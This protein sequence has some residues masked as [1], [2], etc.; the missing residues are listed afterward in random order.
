MSENPLPGTLPTNFTEE[1][2]AR[3][4][5]AWLV[6]QNG[7]PPP[8]WQDYLPAAEATCSA[9][10]ILMHLK[11]DIE[12]RIK[13]GLPAL[14]SERYFEHPRLQQEDARL[15]AEQQVELITWEYLQ[16][17]NQGVHPRRAEYEAAF[18][19]HADALRE[20]KPRSRCPR[21]DKLIVLEE[22]FQ[23]LLCPDCGCETSLSSAA[24]ALVASTSAPASA[25]PKLDL[26]DYELI[27][28]LG[29]GGMGEVY[30]CPDPALGRDLAIKVM[31]TEYQNHPAIEHRFLREARITGSLQH[32]N[33]VAVYNLG[34]LPDG[35][36][37]YTMRLV[38]GRTFAEILKEEGGRPER[39]PSLLAI[40]QKACEA[41]AYAHSKRVIHRDLKPVNIMVGKFG[42]VQVMAWGLSK[43]LSAEGKAADKE[44]LPEE[45]TLIHTESPDTP[46]DLT[47]AGSAI[48][49]PKYMPPEQ[50]QGDWESVDE[51]ADVFTLGAI[52]C[53]MLTGRPP[54]SGENSNEVLRRAKRGDLAEAFARLEQC[55]A[56]T[57]LM[58][59][60]RDCLLV[61]SQQRPRNAGIVA[62]RVTEHL[63]AVEQRLRQAELER[64]E[65]D[66]KSREERKRR[67][68]A[69]RLSAAVLL[70]LVAGTLISLLFAFDAGRQ[71]TAARNHAEN[72]ENEKL[73]ADKN[74]RD[75]EEEK[76]IATKARDQAE[77]AL[78]SGLLRPIG[79]GSFYERIQYPK[80]LLTSAEVDVLTNL[81]NLSADNL[82][83]RFFEE[84][85]RTAETAKRL[86]RRA[87][88]VIQASV[89]LDSVRR[90]KV[91]EMLMLRLRDRSAPLEV[92]EAC[93]MLG[94]LLNVKDPSFDKRVGEIT[95]EATSNFLQRNTYI[96]SDF[97]E[98]L[99][100]VS[101]RL[102]AAS[103][104]KITDL[105]LSAMKKN[106]GPSI[107]YQLSRSW[108]LLSGRLDK[109]STAAHATK[110]ADGLVLGIGQSYSPLHTG[111]LAQTLQAVC[112]H[113]DRPTAAAYADKAADLLVMHM[114]GQNISGL[115][116]LAQ[117]LQAVSDSLNASKAAAHA[118]KT[119]DLLSARICK[120]SEPPPVV[121]EKL[122]DKPP[123]VVGEKLPDG[124]PPVNSKKQAGGDA[125]TKKRELLPPPGL[126]DE[127]ALPDEAAPPP[128]GWTIYPGLRGVEAFPSLSKYLDAASAAHVSDTLLVAMSKTEYSD[129][130]HMLFQ[131]LLEVSRHL[132]ACHAA[133]VA[134]LLLDTMNKEFNSVNFVRGDDT[135]VLSLR[136]QYLQA[137]TRNLDNA[138]AA[139][140][141]NKASNLLVDAMGKGTG[142][143]HR[144]NLSRALRAVHAH[145]DR[146]TAAAQ[147]TKA[148]NMLIAAMTK[149]TN[150][151]H[152][153][154]PLV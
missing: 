54:Y 36:L 152:K 145:L 90:R 65:A 39:S 97:A 34:R 40:F 6:R 129:L 101:E 49:T 70:V 25:P 24:P 107:H 126:P 63:A 84:G 62:L 128:A 96:E 69:L 26:R 140:Y 141:T 106:M 130:R 148:S 61:D 51:R 137:V 71:A 38:R 56:D 28:T 18:P 135:E 13:T 139:A 115:F 116:E 91:Q 95:L 37:H 82:C 99:Q 3:F 123:P 150:P 14:L 42:E 30:R 111:L 131:Y 132:D 133:K 66:V 105:L 31:K 114:E 134:D 78:I 27:E 88:W 35:R 112:V 147:N 81:R 23:T 4:E 100:T 44:P 21:C 60:C 72:A 98:Q 64:T 119:V 75:F 144:L 118:V 10:L 80:D 143:P 76:L 149:E 110:V 86:D 33:I 12:F 153:V 50:A 92:R 46:S 57:A 104:A 146:A 151:Y 16:R 83:V 58:Q 103:A 89:G 59:L 11:V 74:A 142:G 55:R 43:L 52:L 67:R 79:A 124:P 17:L 109:A 121:G 7:D 32:P 45:G 9:N 41:V 5:S 87:E 113:L 120:E 20:M 1:G 22:T 117:G 122:P 77:S 8:C 2:C 154:D 15:D 108:A 85:L 73:R 68:L 29:K 102:D 127:D 48:G 47:R 53:E 125:V 136:A 94:V 93:V 138:T 19:Q